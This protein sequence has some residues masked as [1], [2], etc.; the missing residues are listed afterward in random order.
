MNNSK[1]REWILIV[2][3]LSMTVGFLGCEAQSIPGTVGTSLQYQ[4]KIIAKDPV[5]YDWTRVV[6]HKAERTPQNLLKV[7]IG[8]ENTK[9]KDVWCD[10]QVV[11]YDQD[12]FELEKTNWQPWLLLGQQINY[13]ETSSLS[14]QAHDYTVFLR[15]S[16]ESKGIR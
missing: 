16:R 9:N 6:V 11:F 15:N 13:Y 14:S 3:A 5:L 12:K 4:E 1:P 8:L 2:V 7:K 10:I